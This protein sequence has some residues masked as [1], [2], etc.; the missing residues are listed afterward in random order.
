MKTT[1]QGVAPNRTNRRHD[2]RRDD[3]N[4][5]L[6]GRTSRERAH[7]RP[8]FFWRVA[9]HAGR[10]LVLVAILTVLAAVLIVVERASSNAQRAKASD[11]RRRADLDSTRSPYPDDPPRS[12]GP[13]DWD[14]G[15]REGRGSISS[16]M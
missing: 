13:I 1:S 5:R 3:N 4:D 10:F 7:D 11:R 9:A 2:E 15:L 16:G 8:G 14:G 12:D 6:R